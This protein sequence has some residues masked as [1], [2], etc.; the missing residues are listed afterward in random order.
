M[1]TIET[2]VC[3]IGAGPGGLRAAE[4]AAKLGR[5]VVLIEKGAVG[6][7]KSRLA[8]SALI[9]AGRAARAH[10]SGEAFGIAP[11]E[12]QIDGIRVLAYLRES[13][14]AT[15]AGTMPFDGLDVRL[16]AGA[17]RFV[18]EKT[19]EAGGVAVRAKRFV[20]ATGSRPVLPA[21]PGLETVPCLTTDD[22]FAL[23][24]LP[25]HLIVLGGSA[26]GLA[27]A[28]SYRRLGTLVTVIEPARMLPQLER[29]L[30]Q[31]IFDSLRSDGVVLREG[32]KVHSIES[33]PEGIRVQI[34]RV[35]GQET[36]E[37]SHIVAVTARVPNIEDLDLAKAGIATGA[38]GITVDG[39]L[40]TSNK[41]V[42]AIGEVA[43]APPSAH[44]AA[45]QADRVVG[46][47][48]FRRGA[49]GSYDPVPEVVY[50]DPQFAH[51]GLKQ[52]DVE[53]KKMRFDVVV[54]PLDDPQRGRTEGVGESIVKLIVGRKGRILGVSL[55]APQA[56]ELIL[57]WA[58]AIAENIGLAQLAALPVPGPGLGEHIRRAVAAAQTALAQRK[59]T[60][61]SRL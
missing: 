5:K 1:E 23:E 35:Q 8:S 7:N 41:R 18:D 33:I 39:N 53:K 30:V 60:L 25:T 24:V 50:T 46:N 2:D 6:G 36:I 42:Y 17:A 11:S 19:V 55:V 48:G 59:R 28:Q 32:A 12:P 58:M 52:A 13:I 38:S 9:A 49:H 3:I 21:L 20:I 27:L 14:A 34:A 15:D 61:F 57:P 47:L 26:T 31:P 37:G 45:H 4:S 40:A 29:P 51:V 56:G 10:R 54:V 22:L 44:A 43:G 16:I